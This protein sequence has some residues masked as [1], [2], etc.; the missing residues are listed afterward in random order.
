MSHDLNPGD[1]PCPR[2]VLEVCLYV[3]DL[4]AAERFYSGVLGLGVFSKVK[5]RHVFYKLDKQMLLIFNPDE[6]SD[7][8]SDDVKNPVPV[9]GAH[10]PGHVCF[11]AS[12]EE[13]EKWSKRLKDKGVS[14][15]VDFKW[16][17]GGRSIY[18]RDPAGNSLEFAEPR[19]WGFS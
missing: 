1:D 18:F 17:G 10:G 8:I 14:I 11:S 16:P 6:T 12:G 19:I 9:H 5:G 4:E 2:H 13:I 3:S 7:K 15:E